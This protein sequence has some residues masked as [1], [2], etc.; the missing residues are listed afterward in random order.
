MRVLVAEDEDRLA[1]A[2]ARGL[3]REGMPVDVAFDGASAL[4][5]ARVV[6]YDVV[7]LDRDLPALHGDVVCRALGGDQPGTRILML[8]ASGTLDDVV[9]GLGLGADDYLA[10]PIDA[11][12]VRPLS[13][14]AT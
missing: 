4:H 9:D 10:K 2:I 11:V 7:L 8:T 13:S 5:K 14:D 1:E 3:R 6:P 12:V